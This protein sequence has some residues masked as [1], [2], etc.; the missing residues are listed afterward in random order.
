VSCATIA[1]ATDPLMRQI[2]AGGGGGEARAKQRS[3]AQQR[4][5][6]TA[7]TELG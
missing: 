5:V 4:G 3:A 2:W 1:S 7:H 6:S